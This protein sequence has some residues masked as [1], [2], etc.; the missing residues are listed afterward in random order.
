M[1]GFTA[2]SFSEV[3]DWARSNNQ[4]PFSAQFDKL[5]Y[6]RVEVFTKPGTDKFMDSIAPTGDHRFKPEP[7]SGGRK[8]SHRTTVFMF[9][10]FR[11]NPHASFIGGRIARSIDN[12]S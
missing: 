4:N 10:N 3:V 7:I 11:P 5:G 1:D 2:G 9:G 12:T 6:G 8:R